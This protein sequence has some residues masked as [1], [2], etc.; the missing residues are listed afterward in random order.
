MKCKNTQKLSEYLDGALDAGERAALERHLAECRDCRRELAA[1]KRT[2]E[3][4]A[5]LPREG[6]PPGFADRVVE[7][8]RAEATPSKIVEPFFARQWPR[9]AVVAAM[10]LIVV[11]VTLLVQQNGGFQR[12]A[13][14]GRRMAA[15]LPREDEGADEATVVAGK[16]LEMAEG[17]AA[18]AHGA[19]VDGME[20]RGA[21]KE[22]KAFGAADEMEVAKAGP[23]RAAEEARVESLA[24]ALGLEKGTAARPVAPGAPAPAERAMAAGPARPSVVNGV[25]LSKTREAKKKEMEVAHR[26][27]TAEKPPMD[28]AAA[29]DLDAL[30]DA[31][32]PAPPD[33]VVTVVTGDALNLARETVK[34]AAANNIRDF[35]LSL[36]ERGAKAQEIE[37]ALNVPAAQY[38]TFRKQ[39]ADSYPAKDQRWS[40]ADAKRDLAAAE[41]VARKTKGL[42]RGGEGGI[43]GGAPKDVQGGRAVGAVFAAVGE[44]EMA[45]DDAAD[46]DDEKADKA[47]LADAEGED[48]EARMERAEEGAEAPAKEKEGL[49]RVVRLVIRFVQQAEEAPVVTK[50]AGA[51]AEKAGDAAAPE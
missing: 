45:A 44:E 25:A 46:E 30:R 28:Y 23:A 51:D 5:G 32:T 40:R 10:L 26:E 14:E 36:P 47:A 18:L 21:W 2:V 12:A 6:A 16:V 43:G 37:I 4:M 49:G 34:L 31:E 27:A 7:R 22:S 41:P 9:L 15:D 48:Q 39:V 42:A 8:I 19:E 11:G 50:P 35:K 13:S 20:D 3:A 38:A 17:E 33:E 1:L 29:A 24:A